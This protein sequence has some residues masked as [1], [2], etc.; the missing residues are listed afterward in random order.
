MVVSKRGRLALGGER[1]GSGIAGG[2]SV[3]SIEEEV[4]RMCMQVVRR[5]SASKQKSSR[6][7]AAM[8]LVE[9]HHMK[10][11]LSEK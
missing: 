11:F 7:M 1:E 8:L 9:E 5:I 2:G 3:K 6:K 4:G 10:Y